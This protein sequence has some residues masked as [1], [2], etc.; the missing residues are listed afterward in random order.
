MQIITNIFQ[1]QKY[2]DEDLDFK[3][4]LE[5]ANEKNKWNMKYFFKYFLFSY[6]SLSILLIWSV[7]TYSIYVDGYIDVERSINPFK[8][9]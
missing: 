3:K 4:L 9:V 1:I 5:E 8:A 2:L 6:M 7:I